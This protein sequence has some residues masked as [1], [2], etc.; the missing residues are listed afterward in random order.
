MYVVYNFVHSIQVETP[1][2][3]NIYK[4]YDNAKDEYDRLKK[5]F[6]IHHN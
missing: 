4:D 6:K 3:I 2:D 5:L 1:E